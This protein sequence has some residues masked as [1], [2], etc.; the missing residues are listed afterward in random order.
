MGETI[1][2]W[3]LPWLLAAGW[4]AWWLWCVNW[5]D[6]W[7]VLARGG[8]VVVVLFVLA[9]ALAWNAIFPESPSLPGYWPKVGVTAGLALVAVL[10]GW[11]QGQ[12]GWVPP[13]VTFEPPVAEYGHV[14][15]EFH[16]PAEIGQDEVGDHD[17]PVAQH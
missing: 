7:P 8:W 11:A 4:C 15:Q 3:L 1:G 6:A 17:D 16:Q 9:G 13:E 5:N 2:Y 10:C 12:I 14:H